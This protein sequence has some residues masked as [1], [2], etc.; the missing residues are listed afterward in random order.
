MRILRARVSVAAALA[1]GAGLLGPVATATAAVPTVSVLAASVVAAPRAVSMPVTIRLS[2][3]AT[4]PVTVAYTQVDGTAL[5]GTD[6]TRTTGTATIPAGARAVTVNVPVAAVAFTGGAADKAFT[7]ALSAPVGATGGAM[8][9]AGVIH[10]NS[11]LALR[12]GQLGRTVVDWWG[13]ARQPTNA[14]VIDRLQAEPLFAR[15]REAIARLP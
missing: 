14:L 10:P 5:A 4:T 9:A 12:A 8:S 3:T 7:F 15:M 13:M 1:V 11:Y 6:Y 2:A